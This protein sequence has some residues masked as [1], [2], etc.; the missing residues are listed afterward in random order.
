MDLFAAM[1]LPLAA[2]GYSLVYLLGAEAWEGG[3]NLRCCEDARQVMPGG[4]REVVL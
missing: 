1:V 4:C 2:V 3:F